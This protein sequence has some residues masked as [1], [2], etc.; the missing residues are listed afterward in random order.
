MF[1]SPSGQHTFPEDAP[2]NPKTPKPRLFE[3]YFS[4][5]ILKS[6]EK[7]INNLVLFGSRGEKTCAKSNP[8]IYKKGQKYKNVPKMQLIDKCL[9]TINILEKA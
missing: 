3:I 9:T 1:A 2:Q 4:P 6:R 8:N 5:K 7:I